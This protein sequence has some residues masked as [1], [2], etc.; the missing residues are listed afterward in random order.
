V[1]MGGMKGGDG[2]GMRLKKP[3]PSNCPP[4]HLYR[5]SLCGS[6]ARGGRL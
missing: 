3:L 2:G 4:R 6:R 1:E 5:W